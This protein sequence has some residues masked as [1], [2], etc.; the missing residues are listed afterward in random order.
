MKSISGR[1]I[2]AVDLSATSREIKDPTIVVEFDACGMSSSLD[3]KS[4]VKKHGAGVT[5]AQLRRMAAMAATISSVRKVTGV[6]Q[7]FPVSSLKLAR[8]VPYV[9]SD[10]RSGGAGP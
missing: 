2:K 6:R 8:A 4:M 9:T 10:S 3:R 1:A 5:F 7:N